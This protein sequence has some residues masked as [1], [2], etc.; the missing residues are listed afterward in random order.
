VTTFVHGYE[1]R[2][3]VYWEHHHPHFEFHRRPEATPTP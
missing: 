1:H 2:A 3:H